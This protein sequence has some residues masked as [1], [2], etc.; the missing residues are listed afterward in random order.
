MSNEDGNPT[1]EAE[2]TPTDESKIESEKKE[3]LFN[4]DQVT[5]I[6]QREVG[7]ALKKKD[8]EILQ[9][10][11]KI[12]EFEGK[13]LGELE[14]LQK[15][16]EKLTK[17]VS[18][19]DI[20]LSGLKLKDAKITALL[21][22]GATSEQIPKLLKRVSGTT[23]EEIASD[24]AELKEMGWIGKDPEPQKGA[25]GAGHQQVK[26]PPNAKSF[27]RSQLAKMTPEEYDKNRDDIMKAMEAGTIKEG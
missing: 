23:E 19:R 9:L 1:P 14:K 12:E 24:V 17:D 26:D 11:G 10:K 25:K 7:K 6:V 3:E 13:D 20:E 8:A 16:V 21:G 4:N 5:K 18:E 27:T 2:K 15:K 22:A